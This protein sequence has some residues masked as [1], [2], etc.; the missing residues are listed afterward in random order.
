MPRDINDAFVLG[1]IVEEPE[2]NYTQS[3]KAV[4][5]ARIALEW[6]DRTTYLTL[7]LWEDDAEQ[8]ANQINQGDRVWAKGRNQIR[9]WEDRDGNKRY[10]HQIV[11][12]RYG[13]ETEKGGGPS[14]Q[15]D[16]QPGP[17]DQRRQ[18]RQNQGQRGGQQNQG[19]RGG[20]QGGQQNAFEEGPDDDLPF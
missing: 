19:Q 4:C 3:S 15:P 11:V 18:Q 8:F 2:L 12:Y 14:A 9:S 17:G 1:N 7:T 16:P 10:S 6:Q 5:N 20:Q 13:I